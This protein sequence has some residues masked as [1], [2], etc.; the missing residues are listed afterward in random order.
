MGVWY[1]LS[2]IMASQEKAGWLVYS[3][4]MTNSQNLVSALVMRS[5]RR[6]RMTR[7][8]RNLRLISASCAACGL[9]HSPGVLMASGRSWPHHFSQSSLFLS[10]S[11]A[12]EPKAGTLAQSA[13]SALHWPSEIQR[14]RSLGAGA[15]AGV[16][17]PSDSA[18]NSTWSIFLSRSRMRKVRRHVTMSLSRSKRPRRVKSNTVKVVHSVRPPRRRSSSSGVME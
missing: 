11:L 18:S 3:V 13:S 5:G 6:T 17:L 7:S 4:P 15:G 8:S 12:K 2:G 9:P 1:V 14:E 10:I 16:F